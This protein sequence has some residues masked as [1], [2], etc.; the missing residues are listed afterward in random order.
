MTIV[1]PLIFQFYL[2]DCALISRGFALGLQV[3]AR[4]AEISLT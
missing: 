1:E 2:M 3:A 4:D